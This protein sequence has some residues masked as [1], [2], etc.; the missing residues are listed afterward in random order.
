MTTSYLLFLLIG[1]I[2]CTGLFAWTL[3]GKK[4][5]PLPALCSLPLGLVLGTVMSKA[6]YVL[7][8]ASEQ[9][10]NYGLAAFLRTQPAEF[11]FVTGCA[12]VVLAVWL[13]AKMT[14][15]QALPVLNAFAPCGALMAAIVRLGTYFLDRMSMVGVGDFVENE[16]HCFFPL[17]IE[18]EMMYCWLYA[19][20]MLEC[21]CALGCAVFAFLHYKNT[22]PKT[23]RTFTHTLFFLALPQI[24]CEQLLGSYMHW[25]HPKLGFLRLEQVLCA[26]IVFGIMLMTCK[27]AKGTKHRFLPLALTSLAML[28]TVDLLFMLDNK[29]LFGLEL[30]PDACYVLMIVML[31][32][33]GALYAFASRRLKKK[34]A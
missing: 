16:A 29:Y 1:A 30:P 13:A 18:N 17:A 27:K 25:S 23:G 20:F 15:Q 2:C 9:F 24:F 32:C 4:L 19:V 8:K 34:P 11:S 31:V 6:G 26:G 12:G 10:D 28:V 22:D 33:I 14:K 5:S 21:A 3:N 7:L